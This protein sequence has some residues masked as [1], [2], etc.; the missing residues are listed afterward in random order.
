MPTTL[1]APENFEI[2]AD[3]CTYQLRAKVS[4][5]DAVERVANAI[6]YARAHGMPRL[7][8]DVT[9]LKLAGP[10]TLAD[11]FLMVED[12]VRASNGE[13]IVA[14]VALP[15]YIHPEKFGVRLAAD[16]GARGDV[17]TSEQEALQWLLS[18]R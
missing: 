16:L 15:E 3:Y 9:E 4:L 7:L 14:I 12:W 5:V 10:L 1:Q 2:C 13:V 8:V 18:Q 6:A 17:F 11:R